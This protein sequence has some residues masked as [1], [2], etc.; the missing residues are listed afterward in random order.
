MQSPPA[1][2][3]GHLQRTL[4]QLTISKTRDDDDFTNPL[5]LRSVLERAPREDEDEDLDD[6]EDDIVFNKDARMKYRGKVVDFSV[7]A[8]PQKR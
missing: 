5:G 3:V 1:K 8:Y 7:M 6:D 2:A 4:T